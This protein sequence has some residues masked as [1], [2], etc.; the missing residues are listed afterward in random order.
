MTA[1]AGAPH[2]DPIEASRE[3]ADRYRRYLRTMFYFRDPELRTSFEKALEDWEL[4]RG[5][6][7]E[8]TPVY[9]RVRPVSEVLREILGEEID[10]GFARAAVG[11]RPFFSHQE[12]A[13][14]RLAD[15]RNVV[16]ATGTGSGK[17]EAY[18]LPILLHLLR[19]QR[20]GGRSVG[21]RA[22]ILYPMNALANDQR[23]RLGEFHEIL[24]KDQSPFQFSF[25]RYTGE[26]P[27]N[28]RDDFRKARQ[29]LAGRFSG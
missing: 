1:S 29:Q 21:I 13:I 4:V 24:E 19:Q 12:E 5:P 27:E 9:R 26:T 2:F 14:R 11:G 3:I 20:A 15:G 28:A 17:T 6:Y 18:L 25:G 22:L 7:L 23:R 16:V 10:P 8:A